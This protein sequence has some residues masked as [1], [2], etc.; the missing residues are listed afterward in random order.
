MYNTKDIWIEYINNQ[1]NKEK[2]KEINYK[3]NNNKIVWKDFIYNPE[4]TLMFETKEYPISMKDKIEKYNNSLFKLISDYK[5]IEDKYEKRNI[6]FKYLEWSWILCFGNNCWI[7]FDN[8]KNNINFLNGENGTGKSSLFE[9]LCYAL[10]GTGIPSR[11]SKEYSSALICQQKPRNEKS[12]VVLIFELNQEEYLIKRHLYKQSGDDYKLQNK[13]ISVSKKNKQ[14]QFIKIKSGST[15]TA[16]WIKDNIGSIEE[17][18]LTIML[19]QNCDQDFFNMKMKEQLNL[20][21]DNL[22]LNKIHLLNEIFK[23]YILCSKN[24]S[25]TLDIFQKELIQKKT[26]L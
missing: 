25:D 19:T 10:F 23:K 21:D 18:L 9:I 17:F 11:Y 8:L 20:L 2:N 13:Y 22:N 24:I 6:Y 1:L 26:K 3:I 16:N 14:N 5:I 12:Y 15:A 4:N 7:D